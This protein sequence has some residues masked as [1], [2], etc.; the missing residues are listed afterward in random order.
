[1]TGITLSGNIN[2]RNFARQLVII[3]G[4]LWPLADCHFLDYSWSERP[5]SEKADAQIIAVESLTMKHCF[6]SA[7]RRFATDLV[8]A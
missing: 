8:A 7:S 1:V 4:S 6:T 3:I 2:I 5:L